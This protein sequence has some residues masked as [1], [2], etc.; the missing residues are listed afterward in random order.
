SML[1]YTNARV[2]ISGY[3]SELYACALQGWYHETFK[4]STRGG[5]RTEWVWCNFDPRVVELHDV[6]Y[7][8]HNRR[9]REKLKR[10]RQRWVSR[11][12]TMPAGERQMIR[13]ALEAAAAAVAE[14]GDTG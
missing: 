3:F 1:L 12:L 8:G 6:R 14:N 10:R 4:A 13:E 11:F 9:A 5:V 2:M 7:I